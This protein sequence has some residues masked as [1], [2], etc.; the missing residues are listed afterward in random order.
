MPAAISPPAFTPL[1][2]SI[3]FKPLKLGRLSLEHRLVQAPLTRMRAEKE[4]DGVY[5]PGDLAVEYYS[6]RAS[7][8]GLQ[9][10]EAT[11]ICHYASGYPGTPGVFTQSQIAGW[12]RVTDAV[13][14]KGG[15]IYCQLWH[16]GRASPPG[17][18]GGK[19]SISA[20]DNPISGKALDGT[21]YGDA[22]PKPMTVEEI[23]ETTNDFAEAA[24][25]AIEAGFDGVEIHGTVIG[26]DTVTA[27][28]ADNL[29]RRKRLPP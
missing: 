19:Q 3:L 14:A 13:H 17:L 11:D 21:E 7:K 18:R 29:V 12:K 1:R 6:Q 10:A 25:K 5:V 20:S 15:F 27:Q 24:K 8:G 4:S 28:P 9:L 23:H 26:D 2:D 22:P 16:T